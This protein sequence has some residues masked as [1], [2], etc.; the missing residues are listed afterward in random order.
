VAS[1]E[2]AAGA[3]ASAPSTYRVPDEPAGERGQRPAP[4]TFAAVARVADPPDEQAIPTVGEMLRRA[5]AAHPERDAYVHA[6]RRLTYAELD[7]AADRAAR[8][9]GV[10]GVA[11]GDVVCLLLRNGIGL[12]VAYLG[13]AR[14]GAI[15]SA[16]NLRLGAA[17]QASILARTEPAVTVVEPGSVPPAGAGIAVTVDELLDAVPAGGGPVGVAVSPTDPVCVVWT[18]GTTGAPKGAVF[19]HVCQERISAGIGELS[20][21]A[22]RR[23]FVLP[24]PHVGYMTRVW[25]DFAKGVTTVFAGEPW[26]AE[27]TL[28]L[29]HG[30]AVTMLTGVP[31]QWQLL[32]DH[33]D[34]ARTDWSRVRVAGIGG[35]AIPPELVRRMRAVLRV[36][37]LARYTSTEAGIT[38]GTR[39]EDPP[40]VTAT[41]VGVA[42]PVVDLRVVDPDSEAAAGVGEVGEVR[43]RSRAMFRGYWRDP[44]ATAAALDR[45]GYLR[46]GDL[47]VVGG[48]GNL[49]IV[50][51]LTEMYV[52]GGYNV[53]PA[54]VEAVLAE[55]PSVAQ[56]A[57]VPY[58]DPVLGERG[59]A[60]VMLAPGASAPRLDE[61]RAHCRARIADYKAPDRVV[62]VDALPVTSML[63][64]DKRALAAAAREYAGAAGGAGHSPQQ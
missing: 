38:T 61:L 55:H 54:E 45:D 35:A 33:P 29:V 59:C 32:L 47:G 5:A 31:T 24:M 15:T 53:H 20:A 44:E 41:T 25:D 1:G 23:L 10:L 57:V 16:V 14:A 8:A 9:L 46:T 30:E 2:T 3:A 26:S 12:P 17:E 60:F 6:G 27:H 37:V 21:P 18:S 34:A 22:D 62:V 40:E 64:V 52:R 56:A 7:A 58:P 39:P 11:R 48:D 19:D 4:G 28:A 51:R 50:G 49:R 36:P 13:A 42:S 43:C 63:K